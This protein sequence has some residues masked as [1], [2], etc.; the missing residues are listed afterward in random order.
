[1]ASDHSVNACTEGISQFW[2]K[3]KGILNVS[4]WMTD[5]QFLS[6]FTC[7]RRFWLC[8]SKK[9]IHYLSWSRLAEALSC[10]SESVQQV[11]V[12]FCLIGASPAVFNVIT[13][14]F[15]SKEDQSDPLEDFFDIQ[16]RSNWLPY[17]FRSS[18]RKDRI[19]PFMWKRSLFSLFFYFVYMYVCC[20]S[21][22]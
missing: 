6:V 13:L 5:S 16:C 10:S 12:Q 14:Y 4:G 8:T 19:F 2:K 15:W 22:R 7:R 11:V 21:E 20:V 9:V 18:L 3:R 17:P 1:M